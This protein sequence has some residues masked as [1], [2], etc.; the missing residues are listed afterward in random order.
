M[1]GIHMTVKSRANIA[2]VYSYSYSASILDTNLSRDCSII[3]TFNTDGSCSV[4]G[5]PGDTGSLASDVGNWHT[6][7]SAG[8][9]SSRWAK[10]TDLGPDS[11]TG[12]L[13]TTLVAMSSARTVTI[14]STGSGAK[15]C[16]T[17][18]DIYSDS[19]GTAKVGD[20]TIALSASPDF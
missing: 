20:V 10:K 8:I 1:S 11:T 17:R 18:I 7:V 12:T 15:Y 13:S 3:V 16:T 19:G 6:S 14:T 9:G 4:V 2:G 5:T